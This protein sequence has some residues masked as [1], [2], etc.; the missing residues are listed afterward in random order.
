[1]AFRL[2]S[3]PHGPQLLPFLLESPVFFLQA[4]QLCLYAVQL[5][6]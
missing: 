6:L 4:A 1:M 5:V 3:L 2:Q